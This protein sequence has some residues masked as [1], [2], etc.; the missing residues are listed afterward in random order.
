MEGCYQT[1]RSSL[2]KAP[3]KVEDAADATSA[4]LGDDSVLLTCLVLVPE[5]AFGY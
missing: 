4:D 2:P 5:A 3:S 1:F